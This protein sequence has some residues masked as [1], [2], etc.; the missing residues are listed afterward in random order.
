MGLASVVRRLDRWQQG[1]APVAFVFGVVKKFGDDRG[2]TLAALFAYYAFVAVFPLLLLLVTGLAFLVDHDPTFEQRVLDSALRD[3]PIIGPQIGANVHSLQAT[4]LGL[5]V[6][7]AGLVWGSLGLAQQGQYA[8]AQV[9]NVPGVERPGLLPR[10]ARSL[11]LLAVL[12]GGVTGSALLAGV[13][14]TRGTLGAAASLAGSLV[15]NVAIFVL[16]FRVLTPAVVRSRDLRLGAVLAGVAW[17][18]L[19]T[20]GGLLVAHQLRDSSELYGLFG[21]VLGLLSFLALA[22]TVMLY[23]AEVNVVRARRLWPRSIVQ[24]PLTASDR[25]VLADLVHQ[26]ERRPE[27]RIEVGYDDR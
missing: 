4:G 15:V 25:A 14:P 21:V 9:W 23:A 10:L 1:H 3:F 12:G 16:A 18:A 19:Q 20:G 27:Q 13:G 26:E 8:M 11:A 7:L 22:G 17:T 2:G 24:P 6:G 5:V